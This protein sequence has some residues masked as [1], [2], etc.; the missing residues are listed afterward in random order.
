VGIQNQTKNQQYAP[1]AKICVSF[2][3]V[4]VDQLLGS[5]QMEFAAIIITKGWLR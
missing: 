1:A 2:P 3:L 4:Q 5:A